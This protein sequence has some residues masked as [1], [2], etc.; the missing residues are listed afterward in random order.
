[1][2][3]F[4][5][6]ITVAPKLRTHLGELDWELGL[7]ERMAAAANRFA[8]GKPVKSLSPGIPELDRSVELPRK[9]RF[10]G[11]FNQIAQA[12]QAIGGL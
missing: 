1:M 4:A 12:V 9:H 11:Q 7:Q 8:R 10:M 6:P 5:G 3:K 2:T